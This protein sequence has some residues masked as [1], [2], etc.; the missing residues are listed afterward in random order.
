MIRAVLDSTV[1]VSAFLGPGGVSDALLGQAYEGHFTLYLAEDIL[2]ETR[3]ILLDAERIRR[4]YAYSDDSVHRFIQELKD[5]AH[6]IGSLPPLTGMVERDPNDDIIIACAASAD[7]I[8]TRDD[9]L[10][11]LRAYHSIT[12]V[13]PEA[14]IDAL[15]SQ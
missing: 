7:Y 12:M 9:D 1:L 2:A 14:F 10:L 13:T 3:R 5:I 8:V 11:S 6:I 4:R 15:R